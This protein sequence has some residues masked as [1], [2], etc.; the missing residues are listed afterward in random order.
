MNDILRKVATEW[1]NQ[2]IR[3]KNHNFNTLFKIHSESWLDALDKAAKTREDY[4]KIAHNLL[5]S[6]EF[7]RALKY[8]DSQEINQNDDWWIVSRYCECLTYNGQKH[9]ALSL[10][11][12]LYK[13]NPQAK[14]AFSKIAWALSETGHFEE[15]LLNFTKDRGKQTTGNKLNHIIC[16]SE[17]EGLNSSLS[18]IKDIYNK[19]ENIKNGYFRVAKRN[20]NDLSESQFFELLSSDFHADRLTITAAEESIKL[21]RKREFQNAAWKAVSIFETK[22]PELSN[23]WLKYVT[24]FQG[25]LSLDQIQE[26]SVKVISS[27]QKI[28]LL[29]SILLKK[30]FE[31]DAA[32]LL[33]P[34]LPYQNKRHSEECHLGIYIGHD[35]GI[36]IVDSHGK[37]QLVYEESKFCGHKTTYFHPN[38]ALQQLINDGDF[39]HFTTITWAID[40]DISEDFHHKNFWL[41]LNKL[42]KHLASYLSFYVT[43]ENELFIPH[44][45]AHALSTFYP[46]GF[47]K[48]LVLVADGSGEKDS[49]T[50]FLA[51]RSEKPLIKK[52]TLATN[53]FSYGHLYDATTCFLGYRKGRGAEHCGKIMGLSSYGKPFYHHLFS[54][55]YSKTNINNKDIPS[56]SKFLEENF[57]H[58]LPP[59]TDKFLPEQADIAASLQK[60]TEDEIINKLIKWHQKYPDYPNLCIAGGVAM[61]SMLN[62]R[63]LREEI[64]EDIFIQP[65]AADN[66]LSIGAALFGFI[67][68]TPAEPEAWNHAY[69]GF[70]HKSIENEINDVLKKY[71]F[72]FKEEF[73]ISPESFLTQSLNQGDITACY[74]GAQE[75][76]ARALGN[77]SILTLPT[78]THRDEINSRVKFREAWR[79]FAP[80]VL[81]N[82]IHKYF[83]HDRPEPFMTVIYKVN[84]AYQKELS[85]ISHIDGT[86]RVQSLNK[87]QNKFIHTVL[88]NIKEA[89]K[90]PVIINT[91]FNINGQPI[92]RTVY[93][94]MTTFLCTDI[95]HLIIGKRIFTKIGTL[96]PKET[97]SPLDRS[98]EPLLRTHH[99]ID[100]LLDNC[101]IDK[102]A[103]LTQLLKSFCITQKQHK[104]EISF[105]GNF[106][107]IKLSWEYEALLVSQGF[108][109]KRAL[110]EFHQNRPLLIFSGK[111]PVLDRQC[112]DF[113]DP[114][115]TMTAPSESLNETL[116]NCLD[117]RPIQNI[118]LFDS[119]LNLVNA[120]YFITSVIPLYK[121]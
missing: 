119:N 94:A 70:K 3:S 35:P 4:L 46:S 41:H 51:D 27:P 31:E 79:P 16:L 55:T 15:A 10:A 65:A 7:Q 30:G 14:N 37:V 101:S 44:H 9:K 26:L 113:F 63:I 96:A 88:T 93:D 60:F 42:R 81:E 34:H 1:F 57:K 6:G 49:M 40:N 8:F 72:P 11:S 110:P 74:Q 28:P 76:G 64:F 80:I 52:E 43:W 77:R 106:S 25:K 108:T 78:T 45:E 104:M 90:P 21:C 56:Y 85:G 95:D 111:S 112:R 17:S 59:L 121:K 115:I 82:D 83:E 107:D 29:Y 47:Q 53:S 99:S 62:G 118:H 102:V 109:Y 33:K 71:N 68:K 97:I 54:Q 18:L 22:W 39:S 87:N 13:S 84:E 69:F 36:T 75:V 24:Y 89:G 73:D 100:I 12:D 120:L 66:G 116:L 103:I 50:L 19:D 105:W 61:N 23:L 117:K 5:D 114:D 92:V 38:L 2:E 58:S 32:K 98:L 91:S 86:A 48:S 67:S 20:L